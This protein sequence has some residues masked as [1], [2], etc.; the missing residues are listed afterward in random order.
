MSCP[1][2]TSTRSWHVN[3]N[4]PTTSRLEVLWLDLMQLRCLANIWTTSVTSAWVMDELS[5][6]RSPASASLY[7]R[8]VGGIEEIPTILLP[9][10][11]DT[12]SRG[13]GLPTFTL[14]SVGRVPLLPPEVED[15]LWEFFRSQLVVLLRGLPNLL[16]ALNF[17][18]RNPRPACVVPFV[19]N[20]FF[21]NHN[22]SA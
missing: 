4:S 18:L 15:G 2:A 8:H 20:I 16:S 9:Q 21:M 7:R 1:K 14:D 11:H 22:V 10:F 5:P 19:F 13:Q 6:L 12:S 17:C 3:Q